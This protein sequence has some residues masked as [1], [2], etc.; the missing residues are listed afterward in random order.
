MYRYGDGVDISG[1]TAIEWYKK[2]ADNDEIDAILAIAEIYSEGQIIL[3]D[4]EIAIHYYKM[5][6]EKGNS[7]ALYKLG[8]LYENGTG[9]E[10]NI[11]KA[12][13]WYRKA[14]IKNNYSAK[15]ALKRLNTNWLDEDGNTVDPEDFDDDLIF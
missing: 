1:I 14:A 10:Q 15:S 12:I 4:L 2:A 11:N 8:E 3:Q 7:T 5:A 13:Y 9:V 6:A